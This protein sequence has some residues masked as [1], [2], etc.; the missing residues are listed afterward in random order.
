MPKPK[1]VL[2]A[3]PTFG[4]CPDPNQWLIA[5]LGAMNEFSVRGWRVSTFFPY[6]RNITDA[7][8]EIAY[9]AISN[10]F[11]YIFRMDDD[12]WGFQPG[13]VNKLIDAD[14]EFISG[15]M[16]VAGFPYSRC[17]FYRTDKTKTLPEIYKKRLLMLSEVE[18]TGVVECDLTATPFT[19]IKTTIFE[20]IMTP[21]YEYQKDVASD[22]IFCQKLLDAGIQPYAHLGVLLNHRHVT[23]W[24]RHFLYNAECRAIMGSGMIS[25]NSSVYQLLVDEFGEDG[26]KDPLMIKGVKILPPI[27]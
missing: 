13:F 7:D 5:F 4:L 27:E 9:M 21:Y 10:G 19:L 22:S 6:R 3:C 15:V 2:M 16:Y 8:N 18:G 1:S 25:K 26:K 11:D 24:N 17:A 14:K 23:P 20:K 12:V